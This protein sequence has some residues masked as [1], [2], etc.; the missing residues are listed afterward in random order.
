MISLIDRA[1]RVEALY[2]EFAGGSFGKVNA[3]LWSRG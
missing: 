1:D 3:M 2:G